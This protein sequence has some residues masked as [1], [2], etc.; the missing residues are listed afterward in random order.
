[1]EICCQS[2]F[3]GEDDEHMMQGWGIICLTISFPFYIF[4][5]DGTDLNNFDIIPFSKVNLNNYAKPPLCPCNGNRL[6]YS[7]SHGGAM[8]D[9]RGTDAIAAGALSR[10]LFPLSFFVWN[11]RS[12]FAYG[13]EDT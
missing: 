5:L 8:G 3:C 7:P 2:Y 4:L 10:F 9:L 11:A 12:L 13:L 1:M 6:S